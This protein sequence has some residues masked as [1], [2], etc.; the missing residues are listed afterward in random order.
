MIYGGP[1]DDKIYGEEENDTIIPGPGDDYVLGS[2]GDD[3]IRGWGKSGGEIVDD[4][5]D[6]L[7]GG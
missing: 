2:A 5:I 3:R 1:G 6:V 4:G 7:D